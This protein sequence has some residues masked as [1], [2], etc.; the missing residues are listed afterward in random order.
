MRCVAAL[1][2]AVSLFAQDPQFGVQS[3][4]VIVPATVTDA[5]G[6][7]VD[8]LD[9][10]DFIVLDN[11]RPQK[12]AVD[13]IGTGVPPIALVAAIQASGISRAV[14]EKVRKIGAMVQPLV[15][16]ERGCASVVSFSEQIKWLQEECTNDPDALI[17]A[18]ARVRP[19]EEKKARMLDAVHESVEQLRRHPKARRILLLISES[20]DR[21][22]ETTLDQ[23]A[24]EVQN[25]DVVVYAATY[26]AFK[27]GW[28]TRSSVTGEEAPPKR[29]QR[30][31]EETGTATGAPAPGSGARIPPPE[32]R[33]D[34]LGG[35]GELVRLGK[36]NDAEALSQAT[37]A[38]M[39]PFA[40]L[41]GLED[42]VQK[43]SSELHSQ[44]VLS[45]VPDGR[46][47]GY[48]RIDV[49]V[50]GHDY[51]VRARPGY[52]VQ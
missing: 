22:S 12:A 16:G 52:W 19:G 49:R 7:T 28:T 1:A 17:R 6:R 30:P 29:P 37:G 3:R 48:H 15:T 36:V 24:L 50:A 23:V 44:Y 27:T 11:G 38:A 5:S 39:F 25:S 51:R 35:I 2:T 42:A 33:F 18:F 32:Q 4:L 40:R 47:P 31:S 14:L 13:T 26:S 20:R 10:D 34:I 8:G 41:K 21:G 46:T 9:A 43:L 45:F